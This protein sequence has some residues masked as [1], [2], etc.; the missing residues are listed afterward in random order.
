MTGISTD[1]SAYFAELGRAVS[2]AW[3]EKGRRQSDLPEVAEE[4]LQKVE[5]PV[6]LNAVNLLGWASGAE[7]LPQQSSAKD[8][9]GE[10]PLILHH[11]EDFFVQALTWMDGTTAVHQHGFA[12]A[13]KVVQG[14]SLHVEH[15]FSVAERLA[16]ERLVV[17]E[18]TR[19]GPEVLRPGDVRRIEPGDAFIHALFHLERPTIT[20]VVRNSSC[21]L[22]HPQYSYW[23]PGLGFDGLWED[24]MFSKR[25]QSVDSL[26]KLDPDQGRRTVEELVAQRPVWEA[27]RIVEYWCNRHGWN[28]VTASLTDRLVVRAGSL[29]PVLASAFEQELR[30][31]QILAR[32]GLIN[33]LHQR[34]LL[35]LLANLPDAES[36]SSVLGQL[37][38]DQTARD[39]LLDWVTE[40]STPAL[41]GVSGLSLSAARVAELRSAPADASELEVLTEIHAAWKWRD[42]PGVTP[43]RA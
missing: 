38:P 15:S 41:R 33:V 26:L 42:I 13:F 36:I 43:D 19:L 31:R 18:L 30:V 6:D 1:P 10:P 23:S 17:G 22:P 7:G 11:E 8:I 28:D 39:L 16:D 40:L 4:G 20:I 9:F 5:V 37:Y 29:G 12:G 24:R 32:R 34:L 25:L 35:A 27:F 2:Q 21:G 3:T 14:A